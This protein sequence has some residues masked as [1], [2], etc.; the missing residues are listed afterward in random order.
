MKEENKIEPKEMILVVLSAVVGG[1]VSL[2]VYGLY[3]QNN[4]LL[5]DLSMSILFVILIQA[6]KYFFLI[7]LIL[8]GVII[9]F[10][11]LEKYRQLGED[12]LSRLLNWTLK[13][14]KIE[15]VKKIK[16]IPD[17]TKICENHKEL[18]YSISLLIFLGYWIYKFKFLYDLLSWFYLL[19]IVITLYTAIDRLVLYIK[20]KKNEN[21]PI[22]QTTK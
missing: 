17:I 22:N 11:L 14:L 6:V 2:F 15:H 1:L 12:S 10:K 21:P 4:N 8:I 3:Q 5:S 7:G 16:I 20:S 19:V 13:K 18:L 9:F